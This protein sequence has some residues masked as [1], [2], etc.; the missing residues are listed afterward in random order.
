GILP[1]HVLGQMTGKQLNS[2]DFNTAP[3]AA[4]GAIT[5]D[6]RG[7][8]QPDTLTG[9][10]S[11]W[12]GAPYLDQW[13]YKVL[14]DSVAVTNQLKTG[15]IDIGPIDPGQYASLTGVS[16]VGRSEFPVPTFTFYAYQLD[17][18]K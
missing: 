8:G 14:P 12:G 16:T 4:N 3:S 15:E 11:Y 7:K 17:P 1:K 9:N 6:K 18:S 13:I 10:D 5:F 2:A